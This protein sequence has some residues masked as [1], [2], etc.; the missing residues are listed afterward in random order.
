M[1]ALSFVNS[2]CDRLFT[3]LPCLFVIY[4]CRD[5]PYTHFDVNHDDQPKDFSFELLSS[6]CATGVEI[7][8]RVSKY[9]TS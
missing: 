1:F 9:G 3:S 8:G 5:L 2:S 6:V 4:V 7:N